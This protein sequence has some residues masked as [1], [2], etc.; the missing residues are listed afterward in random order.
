MATFVLFFSM[1]LRSPRTTTAL[2]L[3]CSF[4]HCPKKN[5]K[6]LA[7]RFLS[8]H[9]AI[10]SK[11]TQL[12]RLRQTQTVFSFYRMF[13]QW[14]P[15]LNRRASKSNIKPLYKDPTPPT[16]YQLL[17]LHYPLFTSFFSPCHSDPT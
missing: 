15:K 13:W 11:H 14:V 4:L 3:Y 12:A 16:Y 2:Y 17:T 7:L 1:F 10:H 8:T 5:Q 9:Y 6:S